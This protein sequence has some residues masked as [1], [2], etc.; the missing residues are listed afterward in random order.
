METVFGAAFVDVAANFEV[1]FEALFSGGEGRLTLSDPD[2]LL[3]TGIEI[4]AKPSGK[5]VKRLSLLSGG[6][7]WL[8]WPCCSRSSA[9]GGR[10]FA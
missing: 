1:L 10:R 8:R 2:D 9:A 6:E 4:S 5:N 3:G 7:R